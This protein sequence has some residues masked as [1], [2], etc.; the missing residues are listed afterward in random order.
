MN[1]TVKPIFLFSLPRSGSTLLQRII[2]AHPQIS[3]ASEPWLLLPMVYALRPEGAYAEYSHHTMQNALADFIA[4]LPEGR[5]GYLRELGRFATRLYQRMIKEGDRYFLDKTP[6]YHLIA[7]D[8][9]A[10]FPEAK[11]IFLWR[12]PLAV[13]AS[14]LETFG[15]GKWRLY[16]Y[17][18]DFYKGLEMLHAAYMRN[19]GR[20]HALTYERLVSTPVDELAR[21]FEY[22]ELPGDAPDINSFA[23]VKLSGSAGDPT[24][25]KQYQNLSAEPLHK[26]KNS[27]C[28]PIRRA[29]ARRYVEWIGR[30][31]LADMG[32]DL[33]VLREEQSKM[34]RTYRRLYSDTIRIGYGCV[35]TL[36][37]THM[38]TEKL[39]R[40][41]GWRYIY[42][43]K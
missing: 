31:R 22:L 32:Y 4:V 40:L 16:D 36:L 35:S 17:R 34:P 21:L 2:A 28:N 27:L 23:K 9:L 6:R 38:F 26:W 39:R 30:E 14:S 25:T 42:S 33:D 15:K 24:G 8:V 10:A 20:V 43:H 13:V 29:W 3:T 19:R 41:P 5:D 12:N 1:Q 18:V 37:E 7:E 11:F